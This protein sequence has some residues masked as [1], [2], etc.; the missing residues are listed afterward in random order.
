MWDRVGLRCKTPLIEVSAV[1]GLGNQL[2][3]LCLAISQSL[4]KRK[5]FIIE[6]YSSASGD[7]YALNIFGIVP[8]TIYLPTIENG[9]LKL[10]MP[11]VKHKFCRTLMFKEPNFNYTPIPIHKNYHIRLQGYF[12]SYKYFAEYASEIR[13]W[14]RNQI[15][16]SDMSPTN[17][18]LH[19]RLGDMKKN[20][21]VK[22]IHGFIDK[23][24]IDSALSYFTNFNASNPL[25]IT[26]DKSSVDELFP[27]L[28]KQFKVISNDIISDFSVMCS[29]QN[30]IISN[31]T[32]SWWAAWI[33]NGRV[34]A[35]K[36][37]FANNNKM[38]FSEADFFPT[39]WQVF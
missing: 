1:G 37:W 26:D 4:I 9:E 35:P 3:G 7:V 15:L 10:T 11:M 24:Y 18:V 38:G 20:P 22:E 36:K 32:F 27:Q 31:S 16:I 29:A 13:Y 34:V 21:S 25:I 23:N 30:I 19:I 2:F 33:G 5:S 14:L 8:G 28:S 6:D 12:Q 39:S 17:L